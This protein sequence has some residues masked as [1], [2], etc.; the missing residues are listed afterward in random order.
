MENHLTPFLVLLHLIGRPEKIG[1]ICGIHEKSPYIWRRGSKWN[2]A[3]DIPS[4]RHMRSLL[5]YSEIHGLGL[6]IE[7]LIFGAD[8][9]EIDAI[10]AARET[11]QVAAQ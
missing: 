10:L 11:A 6:K 5:R 3:D 1:Q 7:H 4:A 8:A 9:D 2:D